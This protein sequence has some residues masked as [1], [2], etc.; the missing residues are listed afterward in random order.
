MFICVEKKASMGNPYFRFKR[1]TV[2][3]DRCA[4]KVGTDG[5][6]L[7]AWCDVCVPEGSRM[8]DIGC[9]TGLI[10]LMLA[11]RTSHT[12][13]IDGVEI[14]ADAALQAA[15]NAFRSPWYDRIATHCA[16]FAA[17]AP[18]APYRYARIVSNPP[19]FENSLL[20]D[21]TARMIA[22]HADT[23]T[24]DALLSGAASLLLPGGRVSLIFPVGAY[25]SVAA[26]AGRAGLH[27]CR[28][29]Q[30]SGRAGTPPKRIMAEW[31]T[32]PC[33]CT[34]ETMAVETAPLSFTPEYAALTRDFYLK[35]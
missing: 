17:W 12:V 31:S 14:D 16:D 1:F 8:L 3:H 29:M 32:A 35:L 21:D 6:L 18:T 26:A 27:L 22:R 25:D 2:W 15:C 30:V 34:E 28:V 20:P 9:G 23:L 10:A 33:V 5:V 4:M 13:R 11:Q 7:G 24:Y 19:Y